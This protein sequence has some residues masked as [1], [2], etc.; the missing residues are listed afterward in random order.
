MSFQAYLDS[1]R[2][3]TGKTPREFADLAAGL[4]LTRHGEIVAWLKRDF[5]LGHGHA[6]AIA[7]V[8]LKP[9][10]RKAS[11]DERLDALFTGPKGIWRDP[12]DRLI[13]RLSEF[14]PDVSIDPN[15]TYVNILR[16]KK[17][18][19]LQ[20]SS[21]GRL[22]IGI[23]RK[24]VPPDGRFEAAGPWNRMVTHRLRVVDPREIDAEVVA[25]LKLAYD[26]AST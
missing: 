25:W 11:P 8:L 5:G 7:V 6:N 9:D 26:D 24:G 15:E 22:D 13:A 12:C 2:A 10:P 1:V 14:G 16:A 23:K 3:K 17:F 19:I 20:P 4:G 18:A 21:A